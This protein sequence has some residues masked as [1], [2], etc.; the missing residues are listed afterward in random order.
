MRS[1]ACCRQPWDTPRDTTNP[2]YEQ[3][4]GHGTGHAE[5]VEVWFD[6]EQVSYEALLD[7]FWAMH[8][9]TTRNRQGLDVGDQ[10]RSAIF[11]H[12]AGQEWPRLASLERE[13]AGRRR[14]S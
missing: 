12:S 6:P 8:N 7:A 9:P 10:Y 13:Q 11:Y 14:Q 3:V 4:C 5:A 1:R 2:T